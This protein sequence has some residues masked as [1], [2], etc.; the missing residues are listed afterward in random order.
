[1]D[2][3]GLLCNPDTFSYTFCFWTVYFSPPWAYKK[4]LGFDGPVCSR[5]VN[6]QYIMTLPIMHYNDDIWPKIHSKNITMPCHPHI[7]TP[8]PCIDWILLSH[9]YVSLPWPALPPFTFLCRFFTV[10]DHI[11]SKMQLTMPIIVLCC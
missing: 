5:N 4:G 6:S 7:Y 2:Y 1:M 10:I 11:F 8:S 3:P 9:C